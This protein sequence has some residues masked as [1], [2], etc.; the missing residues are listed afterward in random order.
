MTISGSDLDF[1]NLWVATSTVIVSRILTYSYAKHA[2]SKD[3]VFTIIANVFSVI[4]EISSKDEM[5]ENTNKYLVGPE[6][7]LTYL[8]CN[9]ESSRLQCQRF[10]SIYRLAGL[11]Q[12]PDKVLAL[13]SCVLS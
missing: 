2:A 12:N 11:P 9:K 5:N 3:Q 10:N 1:I 8:A 4:D 7:W 13:T 6:Q